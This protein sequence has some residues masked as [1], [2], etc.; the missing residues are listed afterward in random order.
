VYF[1]LFHFSISS[2]KIYLNWIDDEVTFSIEESNTKKSGV[3]YM[4]TK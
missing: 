3:Y 2:L 4:A 1:K